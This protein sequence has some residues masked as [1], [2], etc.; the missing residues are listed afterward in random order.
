M[1][2]GLGAKNAQWDKHDGL[3]VPR[4]CYNS[5]FFPVEDESFTILDKMYLH[6]RE[7][8]Q[9]LDGGSACHLNIAQLFS[10]DQAL[11]MIELAGK[12]GVNYWTFN[13]LVTICDYC[14]YINVNT[15]NHCVKCG[16]TNIDYATRVIGYLKR[17]SSYSAERMK[18]ASKRFYNK[19]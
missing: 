19:Y 6:G 7:A 13:C 12:L 18:E 15:M 11:H 14:G 8:T 9:Y 2:E 5:Y 4:D 3:Y 17:I 10:K 1:A 16:S